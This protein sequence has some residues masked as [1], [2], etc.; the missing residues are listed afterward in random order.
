MFVPFSRVWSMKLHNEQVHRTKYWLSQFECSVNKT[1]PQL[2]IN[3]FI[4]SQK[5]L[6]KAERL[7][8]WGPSFSD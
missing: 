7:K 4:P 1:F 2:S 5:T 6:P 8:N 3:N